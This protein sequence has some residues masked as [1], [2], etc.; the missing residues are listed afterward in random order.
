M[1]RLRTSLGVLASIAAV[2]VLVAALPHSPLFGS[3]TKSALQ[4]G[5]AG[6]A[7]PVA[8]SS[9]PQVTALHAR[10][11]AGQTILT[12]REPYPLVTES[13]PT[14]TQILEAKKALE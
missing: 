10:H 12:W 1:A 13:D 7:T 6:G 11:H 9:S 2:T 4:T 8:D 3:G 14:V 5:G